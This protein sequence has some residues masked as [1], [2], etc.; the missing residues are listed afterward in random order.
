[1][2]C[3]RSDY[4]RYRLLLCFF[5]LTLLDWIFTI[6]FIEHGATEMNPIVAHFL[7][8]SP[9]AALLFKIVICASAVMFFSYQWYRPWVRTAVVGLTGVYLVLISY[10]FFLA[11]Q[12][13]LSYLHA[14]PLVLCILAGLS[15]L[16]LRKLGEVVFVS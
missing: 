1:V 7:G 10:E 8:V 4:W 16:G 13:G 6:F 12:I 14:S 5:G 3:V 2:R 15:L 9:L 11:A